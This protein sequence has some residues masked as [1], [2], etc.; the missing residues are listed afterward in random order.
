[1]ATEVTRVQALLPDHIILMEPIN[2]AANVSA[3]TPR[4]R[5]PTRDNVLTN[6]PSCSIA[7]FACH[8][9]SHQTDPSQSRLILDDHETAP[10]TIASLGPLKHDD[11]RLVYLS[12]CSTAIS[13][14]MSLIDEAI[15]ISSAFQLMGSRHVIGTLWEVNDAM[16][17]DIAESFYSRLR[18]LADG[19]IDT[20][21]SAL[22]LHDA[23]RAARDSYPNT[24]SLWAPYLHS[25]A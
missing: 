19:R 10:L 24:P 3:D 17:A 23:I 12:A 8:A 2:S 15:H 21:R 20:E 18:A 5:L 4:S 16:A 25:G 13:P 14:A 6:L 7:H 9:A 11:L 22:A 1:M